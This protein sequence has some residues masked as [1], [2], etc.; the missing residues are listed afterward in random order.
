MPALVATEER[1]RPLGRHNVRSVAR[2]SQLT[3]EGGRGEPPLSIP[4][5]GHLTH[6]PSYKRERPESGRLSSVTDPWSRAPEGGPPMFLNEKMPRTTAAL[7]TV[8]AVT[9]PIASS[10]LL[11]DSTPA[12]ANVIP[13]TAYVIDQGI[14]SVTPIA[15][16][17][18]TPGTPI[19]VGLQPA[20]ALSRPTDRPFT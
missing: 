6:R 2:T 10:V 19:S 4:T 15:T 20:T 8:A 16:A 3:G 12:E 17:T 7:L 1:S 5:A 14:A 11:F 13:P 9:F 18:N